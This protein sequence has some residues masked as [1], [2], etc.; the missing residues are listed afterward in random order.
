MNAGWRGWLRP[1][2]AGTLAPEGAPSRLMIAAFAII[3]LM[4]LVLRFATL[5]RDSFWIDEGLTWAIVQLPFSYLWTVP[6][7]AHPPLYYSL[8][9]AWLVFGDSEFAMRSL[10]ALLGLILP[11]IVFRFIRRHLGVRSAA[12]VTIL[13]LLSYT[14]TAHSSTIRSYALLLVLEA[15]AMIELIEAS[16]LAEGKLTARPFVHSALLYILLETAALY[17]HLVAIVHAAALGGS[18]VLVYF[19]VNKRLAPTL[20]ILA[21][22]AALNAIVVVLWS[23]WPLFMLDSSE[24]F[25]WLSQAGVFAAIKTFSQT[26]GPNGFGK[27]GEG[28]ALLMMAAGVLFAIRRAPTSILIFIVANL[29]AIPAAVYVT[30]LIKPI[31]MERTILQATLG[32]FTAIAVLISC[33]TDPKVR[34]GLATAI[35]GLY[36]GSGIVYLTRSDQKKFHGDQLIEN[37]R[38]AA[39]LISGTGDRD[40]ILMCREDQEIPTLYYYMRQYSAKTWLLLKD[41]HSYT[42]DAEHWINFKKIPTGKR[43]LDLI[44]TPIPEADIARSFDTLQLVN[45][46][47][48]LYSWQDQ[49]PQIESMGYNF[50]GESQFAWVTVRTYSKSSAMPVTPQAQ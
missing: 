16:A 21:V 38:G 34:A 27:F 22:V 31:Y 26:V 29:I 14:L 49:E 4:S 35:V 43:T 10:P 3:M 37:F 2:S 48:C 39:T 24:D 32:G 44:A 33:V 36:A 45:S 41:G 9:K 42:V 5:T 20:R 19:I 12:L 50:S 1:K 25:S 6:F 47:G 46:R 11:V 40:A 13:L 7:D 8:Q 15:Q 18:I 23:P 30:G 28:P 17:T